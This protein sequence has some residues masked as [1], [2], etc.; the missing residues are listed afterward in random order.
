MPV[1]TDQE[2][3]DAAKSAIKAVLTTGQEIVVDGQSIK[4]AKLDELLAARREL[5]DLAA[6]DGA[7]DGLAGST[8]IEFE[9]PAP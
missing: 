5:E 8:L 1:P 4:R 6:I 3:A 9:D 2:L 7:D